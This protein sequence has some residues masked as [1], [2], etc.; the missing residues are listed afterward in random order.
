M[1]SE[2][3]E[4]L[5]IC[6]GFSPFFLHRCSVVINTN[7]WRQQQGKKLVCERRYDGLN[8][9]MVSERIGI[10]RIRDGFS[11]FLLHC[12]LVL[13]QEASSGGGTNLVCERR[14]DG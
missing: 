10:L 13:M 6:N 12:C 4:K 5:R 9:K 3:T 14:Y 8:E 1:V 2:R 7:G 11:P